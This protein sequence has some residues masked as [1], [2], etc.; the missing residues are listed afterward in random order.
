MSRGR[1]GRSGWNLLVSS[2]AELAVRALGLAYLVVLARHLQPASFG[3]LS[4]LLAWFSL[5]VALGALG[6]DHVALR[7]LSNRTASSASIPTLLALRLGGALVAAAGLL[8]AGVLLMPELLPLVAVLAAALLPAGISASLRSAFHAHERFGVPG[9]AAVAGAATMMGLTVTGVLQGRGLLFFVS[10]WAAAEAVRALVLALAAAREGWL[11]PRFDAGYSQRSLRAALPY[12]VLAVLGLIYFRIDLIML[13]VLVG[14]DSVGHYASA[15]RIVEVLS[16][17][18]ALVM[19]VLFPRLSRLQRERRREAALLYLSASRLLLWAGLTAAAAG[20]ATAGSL[21]RGVFGASYAPAAPILAWL[22]VG[23]LFIFWHAP[24]VT[25][26]FSGTRLRSVVALSF[27]TAGFN[28]VANLLLIPR[29]GASGAAAATAASECLSLVV[30]SAVVCRRLGIPRWHYLW[31]HRSPW[32]GRPAL[33]LLLDR[34]AVSR[35]VA[36]A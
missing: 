26:L 21:L 17:A 18:P 9:A 36:H 35:K 20:A 30:F 7:D 10:A 19:A 25:V 6:L 4:V 5:A 12:G 3:T 8:L 33:D 2:G 16:L 28:V 34:G 11:R 14:G 23:L 27:A 13:G 31:Q 29:W 22:M 15:Y 24:N 32:I 1:L